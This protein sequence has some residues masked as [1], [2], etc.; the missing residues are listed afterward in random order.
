MTMQSSGRNGLQ[1][2]R[3]LPGSN[4][5]L[6]LQLL[7]ERGD[8]SRADLA[9]AAGFTKA[10]V[11]SLV[12]EMID[13]RL[14]V[15]TRRR[16]VDGP[17]RPAVD[18]NLDRTGWRVVAMDL[19]PDNG[20]TGAVLNLSG[21]LLFR[22]SG[23][24]GPLQGDAAVSAAIDLADHLRANAGGPILGIGVSAPGTVDAD[25][26]VIASH[27][28]RWSEVP[29][30][31]LLLERL[32]LP[33]CVENDANTA[34]RAEY[35]L[36]ESPT[37]LMVVKLGYG[38]GGGIIANGELIHGARYTAGEIGHIASGDAADHLCVCGRTGCLEAMLS[39]PR[40]NAR[41]AEAINE[42]SW[43]DTLDTAG[44]ALGNALAPIV[45]ALGIEAII[46]TG[47]DDE[48][49]DRLL[50]AAHDAMRP[51]LTEDTWAALD[52]RVSPWGDDIALYG[53][54]SLV[55]SGVLGVK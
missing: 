53:A 47:V 2:Q 46:I 34:A 24:G 31:R 48:V 26:M 23:F 33:V 10:T 5:G 36:S 27:N 25:G 30:R 37:D 39:L 9:R 54:V 35:D 41:L 42:R 14:I 45:G 17:G 18:L 16:P 8:R 6:L 38:V 13:D 15:E 29:L 28:L 4:Q 49:A 55:R 3:Q 20:F 44:R 43:Y 52:M 11:S 21:Q 22:V 19:S 7:H 50:A 32:Q 51:R 12:L 40:L 1:L